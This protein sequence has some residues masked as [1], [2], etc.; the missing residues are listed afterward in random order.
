MQAGQ[1]IDLYEINGTVPVHFQVDAAGIKA[2]QAAPGPQSHI[3][4]S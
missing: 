2:T 1:G 4:A 3:P